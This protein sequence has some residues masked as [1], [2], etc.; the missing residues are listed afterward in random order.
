MRSE[1]FLDAGLYLVAAT[2]FNLALVW[3]ATVVWSF[4]PLH[5]VAHLHPTTQLLVWQNVFL[6][7]GGWLVCV[8]FFNTGS[9]AFL[10][11]LVFFSLFHSLPG[12]RLL[13]V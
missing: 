1:T 6:V 12:N 11:F 13:D 8:L 7:L 3:A 5:L 9:R 2:C 4:L 10:H